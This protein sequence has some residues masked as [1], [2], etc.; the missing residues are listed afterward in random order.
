MNM[1]TTNLSSGDFLGNYRIESIISFS[2]E[3]ISYLAEDMRKSIKVLIEQYSKLSDLEWS[4]EKVIDFYRKNSHPNIAPYQDVL[5]ENGLLYIVFKKPLGLTLENYLDLNP[6]LS[7]TEI[8]NLLSTLLSIFIFLAKHDWMFE[9][10]SFQ[11]IYRENNGVYTIYGVLPT[12]KQVD[13][14]EHYIVILNTIFER[15]FVMNNE[16]GIHF[17]ESFRALI[18]RVSSRQFKSI[19]ELAPLFKISAKQKVN[20]EC[21]P[22]VCHEKTNYEKYL[23]LVTLVAIAFFTANWLIENNDSDKMILSVESSNVSQIVS[24]KTL[25]PT[26]AVS[27][28][29]VKEKNESNNSVNIENETI[30]NTINIKNE[31]I[32]SGVE[33]KPI[34]PVRSDKYVDYGEYIQDI[35]TGLLWQK[36]GMESG[37]L[38]FYQAKE[39][40]KKLKLGNLRGWRVPTI[41]ELESIFPALDKPFINTPYTDQKCCKGPYEWHSYWTSEMDNSLPD[42]AFVYHWYQFG[43]A[44]NCYASKN[45]D[46]VRC[47]HDPL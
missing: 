44:N 42:Y 17:S 26:I 5:S 37:K 39:Y 10:I 21:E 27:S 35:K 40:A 41:K 12:K 20:Y 47:V 31:S 13:Y 46:Y 36:D 18:S 34:L 19:E 3:Q 33:T 38:N 30:Q 9:S 4:D 24:P 14:N 45:Y 25:P 32:K 22:I 16:V 8:N 43:G 15:I 11:H 2:P 28:G 1:P 7:E 29:V 6:I 23:Y